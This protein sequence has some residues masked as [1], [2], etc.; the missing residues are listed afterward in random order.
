MSTLSPRGIFLKGEADAYFQR[1]RQADADQISE[2]I[3]RDT[4]MDLIEILPLPRG[5]E[6]SVYE[7]GCGQDLRLAHLQQS[8]GWS[9]SGLDPS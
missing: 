7:V 3:A 8:K 1:N 4:L 9:V 6:V 2:W 5:P